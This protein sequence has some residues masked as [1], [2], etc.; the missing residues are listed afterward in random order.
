M[1][2]LASVV[3]CTLDR[4][5]CLRR[6]LRALRRLRGPSFEAIVVHGPSRDA[7]A[8]V[9]RRSGARVIEYGARNLAGSRNAGIAAARGDF[10]AF[11]DDDAVPVRDWLAHLLPAFD[12]ARVVGA[13]GPVLDRRDE[14]LALPLAVSSL[15]IPRAGRGA[16]RL[17]PYVTGGN[18][19]FPRARLLEAGGFD[20]NFP[21]HLEDADLCLRLAGRGRLAFREQ[22][23]VI[24]DLEGCVTH[25]RPEV[26]IRSSS[27]FA[28]RHAR[29]LS[30]SL[31]P[32][33]PL[34]HALSRLRRPPVG[35]GLLGHAL[36][37]LRG[38][39][40]GYASAFASPRLPLAP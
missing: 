22:A 30:R 38:A 13:G 39:A 9:A 14:G 10:V 40:L 15:G 8:E 3:V 6:A 27:Y 33:A 23:I 26:V 12:D 24:Q 11:L 4:E 20:E 5:R 7:S 21:F 25:R 32:V 29:G 16:S 18:M 2:P 1:P 17:L 36:R 19:A 34:L 31:L 35:A 28:F 37:C